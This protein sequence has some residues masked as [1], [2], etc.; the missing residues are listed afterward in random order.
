M[1]IFLLEL[2]SGGIY[3]KTGSISRIKEKKRMYNVDIALCQM[4]YLCYHTYMVNFYNN[5]TRKT[6][7]PYFCRGPV[8]QRSKQFAQDHTGWECWGRTSF[9]P[10]PIRLQGSVPASASCFLNL[11]INLGRPLLTNFF[12][13][14]SETEGF[15]FTLSGVQVDK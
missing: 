3:S 7:L 13:S 6:E 11:F 4:L 10:T 14:P 8:T 12:P 5:P 15:E 1:Q 2:G 9:Q